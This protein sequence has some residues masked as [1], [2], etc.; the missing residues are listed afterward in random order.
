MLIFSS[1]NPG[2]DHSIFYGLHSAV[3]RKDKSGQP[4][5]GWYPDQRLNMDE[6]LRA[7]TRWPAFASFREQHTGIIEPGRWADLTV[8]DIDPFLLSESDPEALLQ[9]KIL[10]TIVAGAI[11]YSSDTG[12]L[13]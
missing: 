2:S 12:A 3:T 13:E 6:A 8:M 7:Y 9:G 1:D 10:M 11:V 4:H 5:F